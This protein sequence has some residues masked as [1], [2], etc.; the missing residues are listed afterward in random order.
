MKTLQ[1]AEKIINLDIDDAFYH[2]NLKDFET[3]K[4]KSCDL[5]I[6]VRD[7]HFTLSDLSSFVKSNGKNKLISTQYMTIYQTP[8]GYCFTYPLESQVVFSKLN[9]S[10]WTAVIDVDTTQEFV[11][12]EEFTLK[13]YIFFMIRDIFFCYAQNFSML[14]IHSSSIIYD[15]KA[16]LFTAPSGTGKTTHT[17]LWKKLFNVQILDG[18]IT[19]LSVRNNK[20]FA[21]GMPWC[22]TSQQY[23]NITLPLGYIIS[24][25][26]SNA[27]YIEEFSE[28]DSV[29][30]ITAESMAPNW[31]RFTVSKTLEIAKS[32]ASL[33]PV[34]HLYCTPEDEAASTMK[35]YLNKQK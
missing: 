25:S 6:S 3:V 9:T 5:S 11:P 20:V 18:D 24:L 35:D 22:G 30:T 7:K 33:S 13:D 10:T 27:N 26:R 21:S 12:N 8:E 28:I 2:R 4:A 19:M 23:T 15:E 32:I 16:Y 29:L 31:N 17:N 34:L 14:P 1:I